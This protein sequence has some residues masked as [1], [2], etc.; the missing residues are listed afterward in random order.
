MHG[1]PAENSSTSLEIVDLHYVPR[2]LTVDR[3]FWPLGPAGCPQGRRS[4]VET[5]LDRPGAAT[6]AGGGS[7]RL[8]PSARAVKYSVACSRRSSRSSR[9]GTEQVVLVGG[10]G[11]LFGFEFLTLGLPP[12]ARPGNPSSIHLAHKV[13]PSPHH[14][15]QVI[16]SSPPSSS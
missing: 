10:V 14:H 15:H 2:T 9:L 5:P 11:R 7:E 13:S 12:F 16:R 4:V 3:T 1:M 8:I 6:T